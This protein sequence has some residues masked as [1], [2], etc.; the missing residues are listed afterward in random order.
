MSRT[1]WVAFLCASAFGAWHT[2][3]TW[4]PVFHERRAELEELLEP[5]LA[6]VRPVLK[7]FAE[8]ATSVA[9]QLW[10]TVE[11]WCQQNLSQPTEGSWAAGLFH[12]RQA[13]RDFASESGVDPDV[14]ERCISAVG[15]SLVLALARACICSLCCRRRKSKEDLVAAADAAIYALRGRGLVKEVR[16]K[17]VVAEVPAGPDG[18]HLATPM[19]RSRACSPKPRGLP[20][21]LGPESLKTRP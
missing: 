4:L 15:T 9:M 7:D 18:R 6:P 8:Q 16:P 5:H 10:S 20:T 19:T 21:S 3:D 11:E 17:A 13:M 2:A 14:A 1:A 12:L